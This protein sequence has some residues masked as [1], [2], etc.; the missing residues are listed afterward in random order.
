MAALEAHAVATGL[1]L[2]VLDTEVGSLAER[3]YG[4]LGWQRS[5][6][7][8]GYALTPGGTLH[9]TVYWFKELP[10]WS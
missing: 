8:P 7:I 9:S 10:P 4:H 2:L 5:G 6:E 3:V 1:T